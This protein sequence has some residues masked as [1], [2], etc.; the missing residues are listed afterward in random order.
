MIWKK[1]PSGLT[2]CV[3]FN[4]ACYVTYVQL[5]KNRHYEH[6]VSTLNK[7]RRRKSFCLS[8]VFLF[9]PPLSS[10]CSQAKVP[11]TKKQKHSPAT[12]TPP[13]KKGFC[14]RRVILR[15]INRV[16]RERIERREA[17]GHISNQITLI[18][19][20]NSFTNLQKKLPF[21]LLSACYII[22]ATE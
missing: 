5:H 9:V 11:Q 21:W 7:R 20:V 15:D 12:H 16:W 19:L 3:V 14:D 18:H 2:P 22:G 4:F 6:W 10:A 8:F 13:P 17:T 1:G